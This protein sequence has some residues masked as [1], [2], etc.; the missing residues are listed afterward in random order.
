MSL[1]LSGL[2]LLVVTLVLLLSATLTDLMLLRA[3][4]LLDYLLL[5]LLGS[6]FQLLSLRVKEVVDCLQDLVVLIDWY[7]RAG[8]IEFLVDEMIRRELILRVL[9]GSIGFLNLVLGQL[10]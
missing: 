10:N 9:V 6:F 8:H 5:L 2:V 3:H 7:L 1:L 4:L